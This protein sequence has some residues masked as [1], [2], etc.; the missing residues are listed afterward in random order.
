MGIK[1]AQRL[2][3]VKA[4]LEGRIT[5]HKGAELSGLSLRQF[6]RLKARVGRQGENNV[7]GMGKRRAGGRKMRIGLANFKAAPYR[8]CPDRL[9]RIAE[10]LGQLFQGGKKPDG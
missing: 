6:K 3:P 7:L 10:H 8:F 4:A 1:D 5:N 2:G 9:D